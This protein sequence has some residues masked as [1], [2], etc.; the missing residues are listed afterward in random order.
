MNQPAI[1][2]AGVKDL[3]PTGAITFMATLPEGARVRL[4]LPERDSILG[5]CTESLSI[6]RSHLPE[7]VRPSVAL[8]FS[9]A[10]RRVLLGTRTQEEAKSLRGELGEEVPVCGFYC[11]GE[12]SPR[13]GD[14]SGTKY[15]NCSFVTLLI[16]G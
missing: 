13:F 12:I 5:G 3:D 10:A 7:G 16:V 8:I 9:C 4:A 11:Y 2:R 14:L 1:A 6:A 15:H